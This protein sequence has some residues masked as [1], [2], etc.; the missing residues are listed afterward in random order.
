M[1]VKQRYQLQCLFSGHID[2]FQIIKRNRDAVDVIAF[3]MYAAQGCLCKFT[4]L[5]R[6]L[7]KLEV[8]LSAQ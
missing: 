6:A 4:F 3:K 2:A 8:F 1:N 7:M 5:Q